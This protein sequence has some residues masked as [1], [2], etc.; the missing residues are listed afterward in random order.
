MSVIVHMGLADAGEA[1]IQHWFKGAEGVNYLGVKTGDAELDH[2]NRML[3]VQ[4][5]FNPGALADTYAA[6]LA[7]PGLPVLSNPLMSSWRRY[8][9]E[10]AGERVKVFFPKPKV[11][12]VTRKP[13]TWAQ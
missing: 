4:D 13:V 12:L 8:D 11:I 5:G 1:D 9:P 7:N 10:T 2:A 6:A 3:L